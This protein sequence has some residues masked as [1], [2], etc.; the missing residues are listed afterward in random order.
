MTAGSLCSFG[1]FSEH[2]LRQFLGASHSG[3]A[4]FFGVRI[5]G[6]E[7]FFEKRPSIAIQGELLKCLR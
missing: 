4:F 7:V 5:E 6:D 1:F 2:L 3:L